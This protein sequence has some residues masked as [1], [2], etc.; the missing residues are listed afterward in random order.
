MTTR[1]RLFALSIVLFWIC[2]KA[3]D[4]PTGAFAGLVSVNTSLKVRVS[5]KDAKVGQAVTVAL[6]NPATIG[7]TVLPKGTVLLGH[8]VDV[9]KHSKE[10]P[11]GSI[12]I[13]FDQAKPKKGDPVN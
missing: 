4:A 5:S 9:T 12:S 10:A 2:A 3:Q 7:G 8:V 13:V 6:E 1:L 11:D